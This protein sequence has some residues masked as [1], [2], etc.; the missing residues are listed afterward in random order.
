MTTIRSSRGMSLLEVLAS[1]SLA[2]VS[3]LAATSLVTS[4][5]R[6]NSIAANTT[7]AVGL[8]RDKIDLFVKQRAGSLTNGV[9]T[10]NPSVTV[11]NSLATSTQLFARTTTISA[12]P[13]ATTKSVAV[14][15]AWTGPRGGRSVQLKSIIAP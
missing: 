2:A 4:S 13:T 5:I 1:I 3:M 10:D 12:G 11:G 14:T 9:T 15:V 8:A 7:A 6:A